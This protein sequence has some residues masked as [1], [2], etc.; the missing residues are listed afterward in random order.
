[1]EHI[2]SAKS[3]K[4]AIVWLPLTLVTSTSS[5][6]NLLGGSNFLVAGLVSL[7]ISFLEFGISYMFSSV[8]CCNASLN[9][10]SFGTN[11]TCNLTR[12]CGLPLLLA[13]KYLSSQ[14]ELNFLFS[15]DISL[16]TLI[17]C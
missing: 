13:K 9:K 17:F 3:V 7:Q 8:W 6:Q 12:H 5:V 14:L 1:M 2:F 15:P 10:N 16:L 11:I 4:G